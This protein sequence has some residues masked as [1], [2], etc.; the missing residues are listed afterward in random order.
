MYTQVEPL[1]SNFLK[2]TNF[3]IDSF[4]PLH[5]KAFQLRKK[6]I[7]RRVPKK[8]FNWISK[9]RIQI[10]S[11]QL[12]KRRLSNVY[13]LEISHE[14]RYIIAKRHAT[15]NCRNHQLFHTALNRTGTKPT[16]AYT[17][18]EPSCRWTLQARHCSKR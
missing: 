17:Q 4:S 5:G 11:V 7:F 18:H 10:H 13:Q 14:R 3:L 6:N 15:K 16:R 12:H 9:H 8:Y 2:N 1:Y